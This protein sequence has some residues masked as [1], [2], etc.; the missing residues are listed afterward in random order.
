MMATSLGKFAI[1]INGHDIDELSGHMQ[2]IA[3]QGY[4]REILVAAKNAVKQ[5]IEESD[6][7]SKWK[8]TIYACLTTSSKALE[9]DS[10]P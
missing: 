10:N 6:A 7:S 5:F 1:S 8:N 9:E 3:M 4:S 2:T